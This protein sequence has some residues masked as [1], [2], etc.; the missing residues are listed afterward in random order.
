MRIVSKDSAHP[1]YGTSQLIF[2]DNQAGSLHLRV[3]TPKTDR[4]IP[5][6]FEKLSECENKKSRPSNER[7]PHPPDYPWKKE[8][9]KENLLLV[10]KEKKR[11]EKR[12]R[13]THRED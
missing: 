3:S 5:R 12:M 1:G 8:F 10:G 9:M 6:K 13:N 4:K 11:S 2:T 7:N